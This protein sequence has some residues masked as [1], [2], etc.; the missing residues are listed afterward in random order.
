MINFTFSQSKIMSSHN[1]QSIIMVELNF[2][3]FF[4]SF[5]SLSSLFLSLSSRPLFL[6]VILPSP[7][8]LLVILPSPPSSFPVLFISAA[9]LPLSQWKCFPP[10]INLISSFTTL[11][12]LRYNLTAW[13]I[14]PEHFN[15][16]VKWFSFLKTSQNWWIIVIYIV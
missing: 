4:Q 5:H 1:D 3:N 16:Y 13:R 6:S 11:V 7:L 12:F 9:S 14:H 15:F 8:F 2:W 10:D